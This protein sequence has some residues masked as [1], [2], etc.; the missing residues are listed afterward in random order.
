[1]TTATEFASQILVKPETLNR[2]ADDQRRHLAA[3]MQVMMEHSIADLLVVDGRRAV[4]VA[5]EADESDP[6]LRATTFVVRGESVP[7]DTLLALFAKQEKSQEKLVKVIMAV[8]DLPWWRLFWLKFRGR[9]L[10]DFQ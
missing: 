1:M 3:R 7:E 9:R 5:T 2:M 4:S 8:N 6:S 10:V